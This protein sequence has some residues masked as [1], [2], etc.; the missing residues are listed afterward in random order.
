MSVGEC[1][2]L[3][4]WV[5]LTRLPGIGTVSQRAL[6][7]RF[8]RP[9]EIFRASVP[10]LAEVV[11][12]ELALVVRGQPLSADIELALTWA[13]KPGNRI[14]TLDDSDYPVSLL[15]L[16]DPPNLLYCVGEAERMNTR[17]VA[18]VGTRNPTAG[19]IQTAQRFARKLAEMNFSVISGL[20][21]GIDA[22]AHQG[23]LESSR[24]SATI[25]VVGTGADR[26]YPA[27]NQKLARDIVA[28]GGLLI[29][30][31][32]LGVGARPHHF[33]RRNRLIAALSLG[34]LVVEAATESGSLITARLG[35][36]LGREVFAIPGSI[37]SPQSRGCHRL[38]KEGAKLVES[39]G[40]IL[41]E[42][43]G[44][45]PTAQGERMDQENVRFDG[46]PDPVL[47]ALGGDPLSIEELLERSA[48]TAETLL[49]M[50]LE[51]E[52]A[53]RVGVL[54]GGRYQ[55]LC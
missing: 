47:D 55:R 13:D 54:P 12:S 46:K 17:G 51:L 29:S 53:G 28:S 5:R 43:P 31:F 48:L 38:I 1:H 40:D 44:V 36:D 20:A 3:A 33:P 50:L 22:A 24:P 45:V 42:L 27:R 15:D 37:H 4:D 21:L 11:G 35:G 6:L 34:V 14:L 39:V 19:G 30:E 16:A 52:L 32:P 25:A 8:G 49:A 2:A 26:V 23:V 41:D 7:K 9:A 10:S 18:V